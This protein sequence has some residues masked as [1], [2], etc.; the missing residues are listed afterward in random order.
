MPTRNAIKF[1]SSLGLRRIFL[2][3]DNRPEQ[4]S[5]VVYALV[6][7]L[8][9]ANIAYTFLFSKVIMHELSSVWGEILF[10]VNILAAHAAALYLLFR[11]I[12]QLSKSFTAKY[13][14]NVT[15]SYT[16]TYFKKMYLALILAEFTIIGIFLAIIFQITF[17]SSYHIGL[18]I[19]IMAISFIL[20][21]VIMSLL[22]YRLFQW[23]RITRNFPLLLYSSIAFLLAV[24]IAAMT[25]SNIAIIF[26]QQEHI[27][28]I[29]PATQLQ[30][31]LQPSFLLERSS[32]SSSSSSSTTFYDLRSLQVV[33]TPL[34]IGYVFLWFTSVL[35]LRHYSKRVGEVKFWIIIAL[36]LL[37]FLIG[38]Y[39]LSVVDPSSSL[40]S[41]QEEE[42]Q[43]N[44]TLLLYIL[45]IVAS[46]IAGAILFG[47]IFLSVAKSMH[48]V[49]STAT[50]AL[51][52][53]LTVSA[54]GII[55]LP[56][57]LTS[58]FIDLTTYPPFSAI[59]WSLAAFASY[60]FSFGFYASALSLSHNRDLR[61]AIRNS[62]LEQSSKLLDNIGVGELQQ[63]LQDKVMNIV[64]AQA[65][66]I[67]HQTG[68][69]Y[70]FSEEEAKE[71][72]QQV[73]N[74]IKAKK[75]R[76]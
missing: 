64:N 29:T 58:P 16:Q 11:F 46:V 26:L 25:A 42:Q 4:I 3:K 70:S 33:V 30:P 65:E 48:K 35:F 17:S 38:V 68:I 40:D 12:K 24:G 10:I 43:S 36:P 49:K 9:L 57:S 20:A 27:E 22:C 41:Q 28:E 31:S 1:F 66:K 67:E 44:P 2:M 23:Y 74:E 63:Q 56:E 53:Y 52:N 32:S 60:L 15:S 54:Y 69:Q 37:S 61:R 59:A 6:A 21:T 5:F 51:A 14:A 76:S 34:R 71:Y 73:L 13:V 45:L 47:M 72:L 7:L 55:I 18:L 19:P 50:S 39:L 75:S 62:A 8:A